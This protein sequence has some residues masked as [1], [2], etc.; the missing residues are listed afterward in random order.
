MI[1]SSGL[2][3]R[4]ARH[5]ALVAQRSQECE[6]RMNCPLFV[7]GY[8]LAVHHCQEAAILHSGRI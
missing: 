8:V 1:G 4:V 3:E 7:N 6:R 2:I 5:M